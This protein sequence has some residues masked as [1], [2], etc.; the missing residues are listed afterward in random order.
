MYL[1]S[2]ESLSFV[3]FPPEVFFEEHFLF[4]LEQLK[5][6]LNFS[7][8]FCWP[9][10]IS[11]VIMPVAAAVSVSVFVDC[12]HRCRVRRVI[13]SLSPPLKASMSVCVWHI[14]NNCFAY[15]IAK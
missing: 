14:L 9:A 7:I 2:V 4:V 5:T 11:K 6:P 8:M 12:G 1:K 13:V 3:M 10:V 15:F